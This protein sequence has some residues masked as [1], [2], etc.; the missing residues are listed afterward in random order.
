[1]SSSVRCQQEEN[2]THF[3]NYHFNLKT[4]YRIKKL[5]SL[6]SLFLKKELS[7]KNYFFFSL[8]F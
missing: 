8:R 7:D 2:F 5:G 3:S 6:R 1:M 4:N